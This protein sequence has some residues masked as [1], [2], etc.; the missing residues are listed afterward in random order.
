MPCY[1]FTYHTYG[2]WLPDR[3][4]GYVRRGDGI[5]P[6]DRELSALYRSLMTQG[7]VTIGEEVQLTVIETLREAAPHVDCRVHAVATDDQHIHLLVSWTDEQRDWKPTRAS[8]KKSVTLKLK[9]THDLKKWFSR[10]ASRNRVNDRTHFEYL[11]N[12]YLPKHRGWKWDERVGYFGTREELLERIS[13]DTWVVG[14]CHRAC[15]VFADD[16]VS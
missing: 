9:S 12:S 7:A 3:P 13:D 4:Q 8:F 5:L 11:V 10:D 15:C 1:L 6:Q 2:S 14:Y 16:R